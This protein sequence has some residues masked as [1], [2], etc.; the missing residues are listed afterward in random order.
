MLTILDHRLV[1]RKRCSKTKIFCDTTELDN[2]FWFS[3]PENCSTG[4]NLQGVLKTLYDTLNKL[5]QQEQLDPTLD[6][7]NWNKFLS[8]FNWNEPNSHRMK[9]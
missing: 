1:I 7:E 6:A 8:T 3:D 4:E 2:K 9:K 5:K